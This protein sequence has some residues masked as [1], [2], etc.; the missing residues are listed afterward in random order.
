MDI[1]RV[2][3]TTLADG[4]FSQD[5][6]VTGQ[7][8]AVFVSLGN[9][10]TPDISITDLMT[11]KVVLAKTGLATSKLYQ[12]KTVV[13]KASDGTNLSDLDDVPVFGH[14]NVAIAGGGD[15]ASGTIYIMVRG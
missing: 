6:H 4:S 13:Q 9:L 15:K 5:I 7:V 14:L 11:A 2:P 3:V 1:K 10:S 8:E 12:T